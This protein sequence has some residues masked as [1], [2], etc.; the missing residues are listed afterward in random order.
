MKTL[1]RVENINDY[2]LQKE[3]SKY[4]Y[5]REPP[6]LV[7]RRSQDSQ[8]PLVCIS[9]SNSNSNSIS[10]S[11]SIEM[12][13]YS[14]PITG[15]S[16]RS[17]LMGRAVHNRGVDAPPLPWTYGNP[18]GSCRSFGCVRLWPVVALGVWDIGLC[19]L[20]PSL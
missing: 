17:A 2:Y 3:K 14:L 7:G 13:L 19:F 8:I 6:R 9:N 4:G 11:T 5:R 10:I 18:F 15:V 1:S 16:T 12:T 20:F